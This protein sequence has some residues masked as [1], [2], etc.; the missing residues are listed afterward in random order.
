MAALADGESLT[1]TGELMGS[2]DY[3][4]PERLHG[5]PA[6]PPSDLFSL[7]ATLC[8]LVSGRSP[9]AQPSPA[10][11]LQAV[12]YDEPDIPDCA[13]PLGTLIERLLHKGPT[14][15]LSAADTVDALRSIG[16]QEPG[17]LKQTLRAPTLPPQPRSRR[18]LWV[19]VSLAAVLLAGGAAT[20]FLMN[21]P[22]TQ[23]AA[24]AATHA[25]RQMPPDA[26]MQMPDNRNQYWVFSGG[27]YAQVE[28][29]D[30]GHTD[31]QVTKPHPLSDW[32]GSFPR[33]EESAR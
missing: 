13:G 32:K 5:K 27:R 6:G 17:T 25:T 16:T 26:V 8:V 21:R 23:H 15:R 18:L 1:S 29:A 10:A 9:F 11:V 12:A 4:A 22:P 2:L 33:S 7:G 31:T 24:S 30:G 19:A 14:K 28:I 20:A 3:I